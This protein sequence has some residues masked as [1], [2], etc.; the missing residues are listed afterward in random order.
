MLLN[1]LSNLWSSIIID[2][3][4]KNNVQDFYISPGMRSAPLV[5]SLLQLKDVNLYVGIDERAQSYRAL[6][7]SKTT[8][9][10]SALICTSGTALANYLP[11]IIE[12]KKSAIPLI[13]LSAD[14]PIELST[15]DANQ[16]IDQTKF[17]SQHVMSDASLGAPTEQIESSVIRNTINHLLF[18]SMYP[19][20]GP[21]HLNIPLREPLGQ[22]TEYI[23]KDYIDRCK[24]GFEKTLHTKYHSPV[25]A[26]EESLIKEVSEIINSTEKG[27]LVIGS[28][29]NSISKEIINEFIKE[30]NWPMH[31][32]ISSS[33]KY[34]YSLEESVIPT[35][36]HP[37]VYDKL[38]K[39]MPQTIIH[40]GGRTTSKNYYKFLEENIEINLITV[41]WSENKEDPSQE[42]NIRI[43]SQ[44]DQFCKQLKGQ[45]KTNSESFKIDWSSFV[46]RKIDIIDNAP[47]CYPLVSKKIIETISDQSSLYIS[48]STIVRSF[49]N[50]VSLK[51]KKNI[52]IYTNRGVSGIEG[53]IASAVGS[54][55]GSKKHTTLVIGDISFIHDLNSLQLLKES[56]SSVAIILI[57][58]GG[59][60]IFSL[61]PIAE[62]SELL[63]YL[64]TPHQ[65]NFKDTAS[66]FGLQYK[67]VETPKEF[68]DAYRRS[69]DNKEKVIIEVI[70]DNE[71]N[72]E[73][74]KELK[75]LKLI[76]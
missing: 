51:S 47:L 44:V 63:P 13:V 69:E 48:N 45:L 66:T 41:N 61:L 1:N 32:D 14:R 7:N 35:F 56:N 59:G 37:E 11:A 18:R 22:E 57:N 30:L 8:G 50:Y 10:T 62:N 33:L 3:L 58:N 5:N 64:T 74:Y 27:I 25:Q 55:E 28:L 52:E 2:E 72:I 75:T 15:T 12:A 9:R 60:G 40:L 49:D 6:G 36:D 70:V 73:I 71:K 46:K 38:S 4:V 34:E 21:V 24:S 20:R 16:T 23:S 29:P 65:L 67:R 26:I 76:I 42:T 39:N 53:L 19:T 68:E 43:V 31:L 54:S 17:Y